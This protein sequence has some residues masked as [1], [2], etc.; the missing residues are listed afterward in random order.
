MAFNHDSSGSLRLRSCTTAR[1]RKFITTR[2]KAGDT[3]WVRAKAVKGLLRTV[4]IKRV[5]IAST[6]KTGSAVLPLYIDSYNGLWNETDL[7]DRDTAVALATA[8]YERQLAEADAAM[9]AACA[10][11]TL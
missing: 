4:S 9:R 5:R 10:T 8:Y 2:W 11:N 7:I 6:V 3:L 1:L